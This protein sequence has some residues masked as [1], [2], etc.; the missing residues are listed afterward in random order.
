MTKLR[1][2]KIVQ[3]TLSNKS[4]RLRKNHHYKKQFECREYF[5]INEFVFTSCLPEL[6]MAVLN[7]LIKIKNDKNAQRT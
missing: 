2:C 7:V 6:C 4:Y 5:G 1:T 3:R